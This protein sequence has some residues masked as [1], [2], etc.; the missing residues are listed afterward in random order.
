MSS[1]PSWSLSSDSGHVHV[2]SDAAFH[3]GFLQ[4][5]FAAQLRA[6]EVSGGVTVSGVYGAL[7]DRD[8]L[9]EPRAK[10]KSKMKNEKKCKRGEKDDSSK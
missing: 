2:P 5:S 4:E 6:V 10:P 1:R 8:Y 3:R 9:C 7:A